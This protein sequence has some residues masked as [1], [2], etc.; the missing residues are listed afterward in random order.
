MNDV[1]DID[2][3]SVHF[4]QQDRCGTYIRIIRALQIFSELAQS[5]KDRG[6]GLYFVHMRKSQLDAFVNIGIH[7]IVSV[8]FL[9]A[10]KTGALTKRIQIGLNHFLPDLRSAIN[11]IGR[12]NSARPT[13]AGRELEGCCS[14][15]PLFSLPIALIALLRS[16][17]SGLQ[18]Q[19]P[20]S[21][22][23]ASVGRAS[24][25]PPSARLSYMRFAI[26]NRILSVRS[27]SFRH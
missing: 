23:P 27:H 9:T 7:D 18:E 22:L 21:S 14:C 5:Y 19:Q 10:V 15:K 25:K 2:A 8:T 16:G 6:V 17:N 1:E 4:A 20:S 3:S 13:D 11:A 24:G 12:E 26:L